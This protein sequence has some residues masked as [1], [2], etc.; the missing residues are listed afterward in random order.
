[1]KLAGGID[2][3]GLSSSA[4]VQFSK[5][6]KKIRFL[7]RRPDRDSLMLQE[8]NKHLICFATEATLLTI[9]KTVFREQ[10]SLLLHAL[11]VR[12]TPIL[13][14]PFA[15]WRRGTRRQMIRLG[16]RLTCRKGVVLAALP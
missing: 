2:S 13:V 1:M 15:L 11:H 16:I 3:R 12:T 14:I 9:S 8:E 10:I 7:L 4:I 6:K 5:K